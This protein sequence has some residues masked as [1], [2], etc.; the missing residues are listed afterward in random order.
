MKD[1]ISIIE[2]N[3]DEEIRFLQELIKI[4]SEGAESVTAA[5]GDVYPFGEGVQKAYEFV[6]KEAQAM[7]FKTR[8]FDNYGGDIEYHAVSDS[9]DKS[10]R[11]TV[12]ILG[13]LD[14]VPAG[15]GWSVPAYS[16]TLKDGYMYGRGTTDDKGPTVAALFDNSSSPIITAY[17]APL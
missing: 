11:K 5:N 17:L 2:D 10:E 14:V 4:N 15:D 9:E 12:G 16:A 6:M 8:N 3:M 1:Y 13:H 7:G